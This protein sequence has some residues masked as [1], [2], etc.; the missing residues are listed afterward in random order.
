MDVGESFSHDS[1]YTNKNGKSAKRIK[2]EC[3]F[4]GY[5]DEKAKNHHS[6]YLQRSLEKMLLPRRTNCMK[7]FLQ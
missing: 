3:T 6:K 7:I 4:W 5:H 2:T 1:I